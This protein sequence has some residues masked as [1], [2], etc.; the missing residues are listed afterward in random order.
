MRDEMPDY[1]Q[2]RSRIQ[3]PVRKPALLMF[4]V[5]F[6]TPAQQIPGYFL[7]LG[8]DRLFSNSLPVNHQFTRRSYGL[9]Y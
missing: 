8:H 1:E 7:Q 2:G 4:I 6:F 9:T 5:I 3:I